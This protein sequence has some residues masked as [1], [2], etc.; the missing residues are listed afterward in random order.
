MSQHL[1]SLLLENLQD[2]A[3][4]AM[5]KRGLVTSWTPGVQRLLGYGQSEFIGIDAS[6]IFTHQDRTK[7]APEA[8]MEKAI[9]SG[10]AEDIR[11]H[12]RKDGTVFWAN[13]QLIALREDDGELVGFAKILRDD[14]GRRKMED[15]LRDTRERLQSALDVGGIGTWRWDIP[16]DAVT[17]DANLARFFG[18]PLEDA[19][20]GPLEHYTNSIH[21][22]DLPRVFDS[23]NES[24][25]NDISFSEDYRLVQKDGSILWVEA[26]GRIE[27]DINGRPL[28]LNGVVLDITE[29]KATESAMRES[30]E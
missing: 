11:W 21:P 7:G 1:L 19:V 17:A 2:Y 16:N 30:E 8:E 13:G 23:I 6:L 9:R 28:Q 12:R 20:G 15:D 26:R 29:R 10:R 5:D 18:V 25:A 24:I 22:D 4:F 14:T 3:L 27:Q